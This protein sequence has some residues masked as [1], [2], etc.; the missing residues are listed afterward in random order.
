LRLHENINL[1]F[2][3]GLYVSK[4]DLYY[5]GF[6][7][8]VDDARNKQHLRSLPLLVKLSS[9]RTGNVPLPSWWSSATLNLS[10]NAKAQDDNA[11]QNSALNLGLQ[12]MN[13][14]LELIYFQNI[15]FFSLLY[16]A[17]LDW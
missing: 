17:Y 14:V 5:P 12:I 8:T 6:T 16:E 2:E 9:L 4:R 10:S 7:S 13:W 3:P 1:R 11:E 15:L